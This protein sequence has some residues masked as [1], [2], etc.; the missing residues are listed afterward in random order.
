MSRRDSRAMRADDS[1]VIL[2]ALVALVAGVILAGLTSVAVVDATSRSTTPVTA[3]L[4]T[5]DSG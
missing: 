5:Y 2:F 1:G 4:V 3:P